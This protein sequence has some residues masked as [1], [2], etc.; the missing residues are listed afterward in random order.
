MD[1]QTAFMANSGA[2]LMAAAAQKIDINFPK[3]SMPGQR[4]GEGQGRLINCF[5]EVD[6]QIPTWRTVPGLKAF[7]DLGI[8]NPRGAIVKGTLLYLA[9]LNQLLSVTQ[10]GTVS[11]LT[12]SID[13]FTPVTMAINNRQPLAD[14]IVVTDVDTYV[15]SGT[16]IAPLADP[17]LPVCNS[18]SSFDGY[19]MFTS[20]S[21]ALWASDLN[22]TTIDP[23]S[24]T[25][26]Q[27]DPDGLLR[28]FGYGSVFYAMGPNSIECFTDAGT[29]PFPLARA[30]VIQVGLLSRWAVAGFGSG[31]NSQ[32]FF[33]AS[34][35]TVRRIEGYSTAV[36]ST[37]DVERAIK[38]V[39]NKDDIVAG[40][41]VVG[42]HPI[43]TITAPNF[44]WEYNAGTGF[45]HERK[46]FN[47]N[48][49]RAEFPV[50][51][52]NRWL[53][54]DHNSS[55]LF[56]ITEDAQT[57][58]GDEL[59]FW[60][61]SSPVKQFPDKVQAVTGF[62]DWTVGVGQESTLGDVD[63]PTVS[64]AVSR[65]GGGNWHEVAERS[66]GQQGIYSQPVRVNRMAATSSY[67]GLRVR[68]VVSS[69]VYRTFRGAR[70]SVEGRAS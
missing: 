29:S 51:F 27:A 52:N 64:I 42:G 31:W 44:T 33:V 32:P 54:G 50:L 20:L 21:G 69:P 8:G 60:I 58:D 55:K 1:C 15:V 43:I 25:L 28:G 16:A 45:W 46:S 48:R 49:W 17:S 9:V 70:M 5:C 2:T 26:C 65:D 39:T 3:S 66:L 40:Q 41:H 36:V 13:G 67:H 22:N 56:E 34:D 68:C 30:G 12:G 38:S 6:G 23:L 18:V 35:F 24:F 59:S 61:E 57:E 4:P 63:D 14:M 10:F 53:I 11:T 19:F 37:K 47:M 62:F 7:V